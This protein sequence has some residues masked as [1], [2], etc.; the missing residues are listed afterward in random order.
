MT[1]NG[2]NMRKLLNQ[3]NMMKHLPELSLPEF[4]CH[5]KQGLNL[6]DKN[7]MISSMIDL[8]K[9]LLKRDKYAPNAEIAPIHN[10]YTIET[11]M[12]V[13]RHLYTLTLKRP[14]VVEAAGAENH[15]SFDKLTVEELKDFMKDFVIELFTCYN[16]CEYQKIEDIRV[17]S[18]HVTENGLDTINI[19][20][21]PIDQ[22]KKLHLYIDKD[23]ETSEKL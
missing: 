14:V 11:K 12:N 1:N 6:K 5:V 19:T 23:P 15:E 4:K 9:V 13:D 20:I 16:F 22:Q 8:R 17:E 18:Y 10:G 3:Y 2:A 7:Q 21:T